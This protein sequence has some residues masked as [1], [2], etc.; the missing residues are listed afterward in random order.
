MSKFSDIL[1]PCPDDNRRMETLFDG[2]NAIE[3]ALLPLLKDKSN[4]VKVRIYL[5]DMRAV[6]KRASEMAGDH[7]LKE[8]KMDDIFDKDKE[9]V[10]HIEKELTHDYALKCVRDRREFL[11]ATSEL[12]WGNLNFARRLSWKPV[13]AALR[14][15]NTP[16]RMIVVFAERINKSTEELTS[17]DLEAL[18]QEK[19]DK[20]VSIG[21]LEQAESAFRRIARGPE[22]RSFFPNLNLESRSPSYYG[23]LFPDMLPRLSEEILGIE[24]RKLTVPADYGYA[25]HCARPTTAKNLRKTLCQL[26]AI[27]ERDPKRGKCESV[28]QAITK[29]NI[30]EAVRWWIEERKCNPRSIVTKLYGVHFM[31][32]NDELFKDHKKEYDWLSSLVRR[33]PKESVSAREAHEAQKA[34]KYV[35]PE[36]LAQLPELIHAE[37]AGRSGKRLGFIVME[38]TIASLLIDLPLRRRNLCESEIEEEETWN[39]FEKE[40]TRKVRVQCEIPEWAD[41]AFRKNSRQ[42]FWQYFYR[43]GEMKGRNSVRGLVPLKAAEHLSEYVHEY[44]GDLIDKSN[45]STSLFVNH[46]GRTLTGNNLYNLIN[47]LTMRYLNKKIN[48]HF[49]RNL[50]VAHQLSLGECVTS[51]A[52]RLFQKSTRTTEIYSRGFNASNG[53]VAVDRFFSA[54]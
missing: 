20:H 41:K 51:V 13:R 40:L 4:R 8:I 21:Y 39:I 17:S 14:G 35:S 48:P 32:Q 43:E 7:S 9:L 15:R 23:L 36:E 44:R 16:A 3:D 34:A 29:G 1:I 11:E 47:R 30:E 22:L 50:F 46:A 18:K 53:A 10:S 5:R 26:C 27:Y 42:K 6:C 38:E 37:R 49:F 54:A 31:T 28:L 52:E 24:K 12:C 45:P 2:L 19:L 33:I 25:V